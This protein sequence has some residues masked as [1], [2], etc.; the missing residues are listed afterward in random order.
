MQENLKGLPLGNP[1]SFIANNINLKLQL[2]KGLNLDGSIVN[3]G[4]ISTN[5]IYFCDFWIGL[6]L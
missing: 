3:L 6:T 4:I 5:K 1:K 2:L